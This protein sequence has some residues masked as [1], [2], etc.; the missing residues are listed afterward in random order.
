[1]I[2]IRR[3][4]AVQ[5]RDFSCDWW[6]KKISTNHT[7][8]HDKK[9]AINKGKIICSVESPLTRLPKFND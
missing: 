5:Y 1:M 4:H 3:I 2:K 6:T 9:T 8:N 7:K